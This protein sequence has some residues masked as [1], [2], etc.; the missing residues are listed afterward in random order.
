MRFEEI[1]EEVG[2]F[3]KF[4]FLLLSILWL[5]RIIVALHFLLHNFISGVPPHHCALPY[6]EDRYAV[7]TAENNPAVSQ[8]LAFGIPLNKDGSYS[9][10]KMYPL[11][12][13]F[14]PD[15]DINHLYG[16]R[17]N[18]SVPCQHGWVYDRSQFTST[19]ASEVRCLFPLFTSIAVKCMLYLEN[20]MVTV[21]LSMQPSPAVPV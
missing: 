1:L 14:D 10:C 20:L 15:G 4:Q 6:L 13:G 17:S 21:S 16:N 2:G 9:S 8:I 3:K 7:G 5:P 12:M 11:P 19:T 18:V